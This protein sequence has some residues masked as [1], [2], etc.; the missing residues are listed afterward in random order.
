MRYE[1]ALA[2]AHDGFFSM[3]WVLDRKEPTVARPAGFDGLEH[4]IKAKEVMGI[5]E[6]LA[7]ATKPTAFKTIDRDVLLLYEIR[8]VLPDAKRPRLGNASARFAAHLRK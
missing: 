5:I 7:A 2:Q 3:G 6:R 4:V 8:I 1:V